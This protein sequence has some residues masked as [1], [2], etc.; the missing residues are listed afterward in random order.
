MITKGGVTNQIPIERFQG[1]AK[2]IGITD[3]TESVNRLWIRRTG[4][5]IDGS[6]RLDL[7]TSLPARS[8]RKPLLEKTGRLAQ[9]SLITALEPGQDQ[10]VSSVEILPGFSE[11]TERNTTSSR[12][13]ICSIEKNQIEVSEQPSMLESIIDQNQIRIWMLFEQ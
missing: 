10:V 12:E 2:R 7:C 8:T 13:R 3:A 5:T 1:T 11:T 9:L 4:A 6:N